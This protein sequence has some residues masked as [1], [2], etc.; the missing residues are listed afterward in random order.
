MGNENWWSAAFHEHIYGCLQ[1]GS[2]AIPEVLKGL[3][4]GNLNF[5]VVEI[6][7][8]ISFGF[9]GAF[10]PGELSDIEGP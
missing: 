7:L 8:K 9:L 3:S 4:S 5:R 2:N 10:F 1:A 6:S